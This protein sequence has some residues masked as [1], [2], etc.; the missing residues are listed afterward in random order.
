MRNRENNPTRYGGPEDC[1]HKVAAKGGWVSGIAKTTIKML[2][3]S[4]MRP[5][6]GLAETPES[7][8]SNA[9]VIH[10]DKVL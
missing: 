5:Q 10:V 6:R 8:T 2:G 1:S 4:K 3:S 7:V 9:P